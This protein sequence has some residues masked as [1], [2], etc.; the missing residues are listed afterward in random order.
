MTM[1]RVDLITLVPVFLIF[2]ASA[3]GESIKA[4]VAKIDITPP[5]GLYLLGSGE[6][7]ATGTLDPL[8]ARALVLETG[9]KRI[10]LVTL[11]LCRV[12][13]APLLDQLRERVRAHSGIN[14]LIVTASHTH[15]GPIIPIRESLPLDEMTGWQKRA[16]E[17]TA[18]AVDEARGRTEPVHIGA[19]YGVSYIGHNRR[20]LN[21]DGTVTMFFANPT[22]IPTSPVD[23]TVAV[24]RM[25]SIGGNPIAV[26]VNY[27]CH[28]VVIM[29]KLAQYSAD[30]PGA[31]CN[32]VEKGLDNRTLCMFLQG[33]AGDIDTYYTGVAPEQDPPAKLRWTADRIG[34]E[35]LRVARSIRTAE[36]ADSSIDIVEDRLPFRWRWGAGQFEQVMRDINPPALLPYYVPDVKPILDVPTQTVLINKRLAVMTVPGEPFVELQ[37]DWRARCPVTDCLF[38]GYAN[39]FFSYFPTIK[40]AVEGGHGGALWTRVEP[41]AGERM[42]DNAVIRTYEMLGRLSHK[43]EP[44]RELRKKQRA[45]R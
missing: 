8:F 28:P 7:K 29:G 45:D 12:F 40:A 18:A 15:S 30:F 41:G 33:G 1:T 32:I 44:P 16:M 39:G 38:L 25:D 3:P 43:P 35:A 4:G 23:P 6:V 19:G 11:D 21:P 34:A 27:A 5:P 10:A 22:R 9:A 36:Q 14:H 24:V 17:Q 2:S 42:V 20:I 37:M 31:M 26:L 13:Q